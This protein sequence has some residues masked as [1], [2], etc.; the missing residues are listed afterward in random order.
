[1][2][3]VSFSIDEIGLKTLPLRRSEDIIELIRN[4]DRVRLSTTKTL[5]IDGTDTGVPISSFLFYLQKAARRL[6]PLVVDI[7]R[8][9][10][11]PPHLVLNKDAKKS[12]N[13][14]TFN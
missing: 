1:M 13:W 10:Q 2:D 7:V 14:T 3:G 5:M 6:E 8:I 12:G 9:L 11:I 4:N